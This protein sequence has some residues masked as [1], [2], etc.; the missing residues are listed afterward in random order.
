MHL[1]TEKI[2]SRTLLWRVPSRMATAQ[3]GKEGKASAEGIGVPAIAGSGAEMGSVGTKG[4]SASIPA[5]SSTRDPQ[6]PQ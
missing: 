3:D 1:A 6:A 5:R 4:A 2:F